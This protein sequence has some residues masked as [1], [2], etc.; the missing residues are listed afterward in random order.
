MGIVRN[1]N[2]HLLKL[3]LKLGSILSIAPNKGFMAQRVYQTL[4]SFFIAGLVMVAFIVS[5][6]NNI[7]NRY[8]TFDPLDI[9]IDLLHAFVLITLTITIIV[10][11]TV[12][13]KSWKSFLKELLTTSAFFGWP[14][15]YANRVDIQI[16]GLHIIFILKV[17]VDTILW[18]PS[19]GI[20]IFSFY[21]IRTICEYY[22]VLSV[23]IMINVNSTIRSRYRTL[24]DSF[25]YSTNCFSKPY[26]PA[27]K[28]I[29]Q[30][31]SGRMR[32]TIKNCQNMYRNLNGLVVLFNTI[33]GY[34]I[35]LIMAYTVMAILDGMYVTIRHTNN[36]HSRSILL[37][38]WNAAMSMFVLVSIGIM[39]TTT[40]VKQLPFS[41]SSHG[42]NL[43]MWYYN[44]GSS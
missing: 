36:I 35:L 7:L 21:I 26:N 38:L 19:V 9:T 5:E 32:C 3:L 22:A 41:A 44:S 17:L 40:I 43:F 10:G 30:N 23:T 31:L 6:Y 1:E 8:G 4:Y 25:Q 12:Y 2:V 37:R 34:Q 29:A 18:I 28:I 13:Y 33:F 42:N 15:G 20:K 24:N 16:V 14:K 39:S 27:T 11:P